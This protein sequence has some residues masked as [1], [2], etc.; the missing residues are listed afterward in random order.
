MLATWML[1]HKVHLDIAG[2]GK[3]TVAVGSTSAPA[4]DTAAP[5]ADTAADAIIPTSHVQ[6]DETYFSGPKYGKGK[7]RHKV[8]ILETFCVVNSKGNTTDFACAPVEGKSWAHLK[9]LI[10][11]NVPAGT[12][13]V[14]T[15][16]AKGYLKVSRTHRHITVNHSKTF[17]NRLNGAC[18]NNIEGFHKHL[19]K[20]LQARGG[21]FEFAWVWED[22]PRHGQRGHHPCLTQKIEVEGT[23]LC[24]DVSGPPHGHQ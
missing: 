2:E 16:C 3:C 14:V 6:V 7:M 17:V 5:A 9:G 10:L 1:A 24:V 8:F 22:F 12:V 13:P 11:K 21:L 18:T 19:K 20:L 15:D 23:V 4:A